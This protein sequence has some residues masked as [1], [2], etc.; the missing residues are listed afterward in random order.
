LLLAPLLVLGGLVGVAPSAAGAELE[1]RQDQAFR[2]RSDVR[3]YRYSE[4][5]TGGGRPTR[6]GEVTY[7]WPAGHVDLVITT[8]KSG[9]RWVVMSPY[10]QTSQFDGLVRNGDEISLAEGRY[11]GLGAT[12]MI[13]KS[14]RGVTVKTIICKKSALPSLMS[15]AL[16]L[17]IPGLK[18][19]VGVG[20]W[21]GS[22]LVPETG[23]RCGEVTSLTVPMSISS[24]GRLHLQPTTGSGAVYQGSTPLG[25]I[26]LV[27]ENWVTLTAT[28]R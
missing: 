12:A 27:T 4:V 21:A 22:L 9:D 19:V 23:T 2:I 26:K 20:L 25:D 6:T 7:R 3:E 5:Y 1:C 13:E 11:Q 18:Y 15:F 17:P 28:T 10:A 14:G 24:D 16:G 8:C